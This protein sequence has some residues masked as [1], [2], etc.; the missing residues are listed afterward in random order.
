MEKGQKWGQKGGFVEIWR[1]YLSMP[2]LLIVKLLILQLS[3]LI[4]GKTDRFGWKYGETGRI[5]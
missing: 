5:G 2:K 4:F 1:L 3:G